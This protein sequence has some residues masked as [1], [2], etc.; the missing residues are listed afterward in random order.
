[1]TPVSSM[2]LAASSPISPPVPRP[3]AKPPPGPFGPIAS[4]VL[5]PQRRRSVQALLPCAS[6]LGSHE[7]I[8]RRRTGKAKMHLQA[9]R[10]GWLCKSRRPL[11]NQWT[12]KG[13]STVPMSCRM[14]TSAISS[15]SVA[16]RLIITKRA[17]FRFASK[18]KPGAGHTQNERRARK[19]NLH[20]KGELAGRAH[21]ELGPPQPE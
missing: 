8:I 5:Q 6:N 13:D 3:V 9:K 2:T 1:M 18:A 21:L 10:G 15:N 12:M 4:D 7:D 11:P 17:P 16:S 20:D 14:T 19:K